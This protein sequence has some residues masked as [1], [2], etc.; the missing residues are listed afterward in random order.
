MRPN[1]RMNPENRSVLP[2]GSAILGS[3]KFFLNPARSN[4]IRSLRTLYIDPVDDLTDSAQA[5]HSSEKSARREKT[6][7]W[8]MGLSHGGLGVQNQ[9]NLDF[10]IDAV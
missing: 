10:G 4:G 9:S 7:R 8:L 6:F 2:F 3:P 1:M 5:R